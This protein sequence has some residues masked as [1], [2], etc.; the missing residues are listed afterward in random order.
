MVAK[1]EI[2]RRAFV[3]SMA[4]AGLPAAETGGW[5]QLFDGRSL[6]GWRPSENQAT[7]KVVEGQLASEG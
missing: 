2:T 4:A 5:V 3:G 6:D 1:S 7:W